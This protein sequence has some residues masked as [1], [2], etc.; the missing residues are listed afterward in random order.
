MNNLYLL[1]PPLDLY[2]SGTLSVASVPGITAAPFY[3]FRFSSGSKATSTQKPR[4]PQAGQV[5]FR[6]AGV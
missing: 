4:C 6:V 1:Q 2:P 3:A 5:S